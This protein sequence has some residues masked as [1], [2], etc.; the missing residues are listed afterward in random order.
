MSL[1]GLAGPLA[2]M[3]HPYGSGAYAEAWRHRG[4]DPAAPPPHRTLTAYDDDL[5]GEGAGERGDGDAPMGGGEREASAAELGQE[6]RVARTENEPSKKASKAGGQGATKAGEAGANGSGSKPGR[7]SHSVALPQWMDLD[8]ETLPRRA[9]IAVSHD[10]SKAGKMTMK[11]EVPLGDPASG[12][13]A[14]S[15]AMRPSKL[16]E[17]GAVGELTVQ[18]QTARGSESEFSQMLSLYSQVKE[19]ASKNK[20]LSTM[21][22][23]QSSSRSDGETRRSKSSGAILEM[24][25]APGREGRA[26]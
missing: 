21:L 4:S 6:G 2:E 25:C 17:F 26:S 1:D 7:R 22:E 5:L 9:P 24:G 10:T 14:P 19:Q 16:A 3:A 12:Q 11:R 15:I 23:G 13:Q 18:L 8:Q 20:A